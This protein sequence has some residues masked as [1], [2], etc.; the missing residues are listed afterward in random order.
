MINQ[1]SIAVLPFEN[2]SSDP[3]NEYFADGMTEE[4]INALSKIQG[5]KVTARTSSF[6]YK[7]TKTD[8]RHIGNELGVAT[9]L[10]GSIRKARD[11][12]R[13]SAQLIRTDNGFHIWSENFDRK[14]E[15]IFDLQEEI[16]LLIAEKIRENFGHLDIAEHLVENRT[17]NVE[18]YQ[19][20][21]RGRFYELNWKLEDFK[22]AI[23]FY[24]RC[25][26]LDPNYYPPYF[27][28]VQCYGI[29]ASWNHIGK[30]SALSE[31]Y[32]YLEKGLLL[33]P[34]APEGYFALATTAYWANWE[35]E[36]ALEY[37][38]K[39][40]AISPN[41][42][43]ALEATAECYTGIGDFAKA[44]S[45]VDK[46]MVY[47]P[48]S[49][50]HCFTKG[51][52]Y[53]L[54]KEYVESLKWMNKSLEIDAQWQLALQI[55]ACCYILM[56]DKQSLY[57][58][59]ASSSFIQNVSEFKLLYQFRNEIVPEN[60]VNYEPKSVGYLPWEVYFPLYQNDEN[61]ALVAL[62]SGV[63]NH[64][65]QYINF[66]SDPLM[67]PLKSS[68]EYIHLCNTTFKKQSPNVVAK[69]IQVS[70]PEEIFDLESDEFEALL[71]KVMQEDQL[72]LNPELNL[73]T[74]AEKI[75]LHPN[76]LSWL[77]NKKMGKN[78]NDFVNSY[79]LETFKAKSIDPANKHLTILGLAYESGFRS[80]SVFN[81][82][83]KRETGLTPKKWMKQ[84]LK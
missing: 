19:H 16:S 81:D 26:E 61:A 31:G 1:K 54:R 40:L 82:F 57:D 58:F 71:L 56:E 5:L 13:I 45:F 27:G 7:N 8:V 9:V 53:Y 2:L 3:E 36:S 78:F 42:S 75:E 28:I 76:K 48:L 44:M 30:E 39:A 23:E 67:E 65:G 43:A 10:E 6:V 74:L 47:N 50:N 4:I 15:N 52:L 60:R 73:R 46:A 83:F 62:K 29:L 33:K 17:T 35:V 69:P 32:R 38:K 20:Y 68:S 77:L 18:A 11:T 14:L 84:H 70:Q 25:I 41:Y 51:Y 12:V 64:L 21:L 37:L 55:K 34:D 49:A 63:N 22:K 80:K 72:F 66:I 79:R 24:K 59:L